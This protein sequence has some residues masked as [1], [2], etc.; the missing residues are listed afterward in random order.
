MG[1]GCEV[2]GLVGTVD[3]VRKK[4]SSYEWKKVADGVDDVESRLW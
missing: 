4:V 2:G 1:Y 3:G